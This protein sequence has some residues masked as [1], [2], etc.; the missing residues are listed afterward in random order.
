MSMSNYKPT[1][2]GMRVMLYVA[3]ALVFIV[4]IQLFV[5]S[6]QTDQFFAWTIA[7]PLTAAFLGA[8]Y[9]SSCILEFLSAR[10]KLWSNARIAVPAVLLFTALTFVV[11]MLHIDKFHLGGQF[12]FIT[13]ALT[14]VWILVYLSVPLIMGILLFLQVRRHGEDTP[15]QHPLPI[16]LRRVTAIYAIILF[17]I[18]V[19]LLIT[20]ESIIGAWAWKLTPLTGRAIGAWAIGLGTAVAHIVIE[21]D[22][23]RVLPAMAG[24]AL[25]SLLELVAIARYASFFNF[26]SLSGILFLVFLV[27]LLILS[28]YGV[29]QAWRVRRATLG[30]DDGQ[31]Q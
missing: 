9:W 13:Q 10:E 26:G 23:R 21:A 25:F 19:L 16:W 11:T 27:T 15:H 7:N 5:F 12:A 24:L 8:A 29:Y 31:S 18:G 28:M 17:P 30:H 3:S 1:I 22:W 20:P 14:V 6:E 2:L 4:G